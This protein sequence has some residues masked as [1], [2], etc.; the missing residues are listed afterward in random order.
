MWS[1]FHIFRICFFPPPLRGGV[2]LLRGSRERRN[3]F[4]RLGGMCVCVCVHVHVV[5]VVNVV[6]DVH[7]VNDV[8]MCV[9][10]CMLCVLV[11]VLHVCCMC[12]LRVYVVSWQV[13]KCTIL[14]MDKCVC[15]YC[16]TSI[17]D[18]SHIVLCVCCRQVNK[19]DN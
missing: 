13:M 14:M 7:D 9:C 6:N 10:M 17:S 16:F 15:G 11:G 4:S 18:A 8:S 5:N 3:R 2:F 12:M 19:E 1:V